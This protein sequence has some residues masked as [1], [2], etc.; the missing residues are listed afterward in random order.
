M[1][2]CTTHHCS[3]DCREAQVKEMCDYLL[4]ALRQKVITSGVLQAYEAA[5]TIACDLYPDK[6]ADLPTFDFGG[7]KL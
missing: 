3:C 4:W 7:K 2:D 1:K 6:C 5:A